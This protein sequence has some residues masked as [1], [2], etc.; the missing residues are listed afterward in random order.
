MAVNAPPSIDPANDGTMTG[1]LVQTYKKLLQRTDDMLPAKIISYDRGTNRA[2]VQPMIVVVTTAGEQVARAPIASVPVF[3]LGGGNYVLN[4]PMNPGNLGW[5]KASDRD[6]SLFLQAYSTAKP[7]TGRIHSFE[8]S[9]FLPD[10]MTGWEIQSEDEDNVVLQTLDGSQRIAIW[11]D[12]V[13]ITSDNRVVIDAPITEFTGA[14]IN[15]TNPAYDDYAYFGGEIRATDEI[16]AKYGTDDIA[17][18]TH[19]HV[20]SGGSGDS[21]EPKPA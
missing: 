4:F 1:M 17:L 5:I 14:I 3:Q 2:Q 20:D 8:D 11:G 9:V 7:N 19:V 16:T 10:V 15:G 18:S 21:G 6:L 13:K 12:R